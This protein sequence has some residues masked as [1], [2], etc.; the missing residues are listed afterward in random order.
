MSKNNEDHEIESVGLRLGELGDDTVVS[1]A[2]LAKMI[3]RHRVSVKRAV[4]R[5]E[6][7]RPI[8]LFGKPSWTV[9]SLLDHFHTLQESAVASR[10]KAN[11]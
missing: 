5:G 9:K 4:E 10:S 1:E 2:E 11:T 8:K 6:L 3:G 7:P